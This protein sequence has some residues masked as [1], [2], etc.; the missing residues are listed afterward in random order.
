METIIGYEKISKNS[1]VAIKKQFDNAPKV[2]HHYINGN[3]W[4]FGIGDLYS[5]KKE[6]EKM[7][8]KKYERSY[9]FHFFGKDFY[10]NVPRYKF[11][12]TIENTI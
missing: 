8:D 7:R 10:G 4:I 6:S 11:W 2:R 5:T 3:L 1:L 12:E 9:K